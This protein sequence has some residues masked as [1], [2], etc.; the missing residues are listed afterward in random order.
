[1]YIGEHELQNVSDGIVFKLYKAYIVANSYWDERCYDMSELDEMTYGWSTEEIIDRMKEVDTSDEYLWEQGGDYVSGS[2][3]DYL[4]SVADYYGLANW[5]TNGTV[6]QRELEDEEVAE[7]FF[8]GDYLDID[9][10]TLLLEHYEHE[11]IL[12][13][14]GGDIH[15][16][17][18][19]ALESIAMDADD[20]D[21]G[22][23]EAVFILKGAEVV[24]D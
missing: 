18:K 9:E 24:F 23:T 11:E 20:D 17:E 6:W 16:S 1:M 2:E 3:S 5:L 21:E 13:Q 10:W 15:K 12:N 4:E 22:A 14:R 19:E 8:Y 7:V